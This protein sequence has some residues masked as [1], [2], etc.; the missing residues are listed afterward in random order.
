MSIARH[1][2]TF[3]LDPGTY[4]FVQQLESQ[5]SPPLETLSPTEARAV[6]SRLQAGHVTTIPAE[7][8]D[9]MIPGGPTGQV[10]IRIVRPS[11]ISGILPV[12]LYFHGGGWVL[13]DKDTHDRLIRELSAGAQAA[14]VFVEYSRSPEAHYPVAIE[15]DYAVATWIAAH[16]RE[17][18]LD[19]SRLVVAGDSVGGNMVAAMTLLAKERGGPQFALQILFYPVTNAQFDTSSFREFADGPWL[20][21]SATQWFW[22]SYAPD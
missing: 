6:L 8:E 19:A 21:R 5:G 12:V 7:I 16:G 22:D 15:Q 9:R 20:T 2:P 4:A 13:G 1:T 18:G 17:V 10:S 14:V 3:S 11:G